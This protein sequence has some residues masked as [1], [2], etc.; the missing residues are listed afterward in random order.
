MPDGPLNVKDFA[1]SIKAQ[2]PDYAEVDDYELT[3]RIL[4]KYPE[5]KDALAPTVYDKTLLRAN[6]LGIPTKFVDNLVGGESSWKANVRDSVQGA[7]GLLQVM[8]DNPGGDTR[9]IGKKTYNL[10]N[11]NDN[12]E[13]GL[14]Y[15]KQG[16]DKY[17]GALD[18]TAAYYFSGSHA[19][20]PE[21]WDQIRDQTGT[22]VSQYVRKATRGLDSRAARIPSVVYPQN[23]TPTAQRQLLPRDANVPTDSTDTLSDAPVPENTQP[24]TEAGRAKVLASPDFG[25]EM[26]SGQTPAERAAMAEAQNRPNQIDD[27][28]AQA[29][30]FM[31]AQHQAVL[32]Q[33]AAALRQQAQA[34]QLQARAAQVAQASATSLSGFTGG[35][36]G[37]RGPEVQDNPQQPQEPIPAT[38]GVGNL[39]MAEG[40]ELNASGMGAGELRRRDDKAMQTARILAEEQA[41][42]GPGLE[43]IERRLQARG[44]GAPPVTPSPELMKK[45]EAARTSSVA[46]MDV[47]SAANA[48][49][50][51]PRAEMQ[52][53]MRA[54]DA[55]IET[56]AGKRKIESMAQ[57]PIVG[58]L[59]ASIAQQWP[60]FA[61]MV[62]Q[63]LGNVIQNPES[64]SP[65]Q[66]ALNYLNPAVGD[67]WKKMVAPVSD[68][69]K[70]RAEIN[71]AI[72]NY[73]P[74]PQ[75]A[76]GMPET[77]TRA[78]VNAGYDASRIGAIMAVTG[79]PLPVVLVGESAATNADKPFPTQLKENAKAL[80]IGLALHYVPTAIEKGLEKVPGIG[81]IA[82]AH[83]EAAARTVGA[84][85]F[86][87]LSGA[88]SAY[89][90]QDT[91]HVVAATAAG[92]VIGG[93][94]AGGGPMRLGK[95]VINRA[96]KSE[97]LPEPANDFLAS[98]NKLGKG[99]VF[100][101]DGRAASVY[102]DKDTGDAFG[103][104]LTPEQARAYD[105][106]IITGTA[107]PVRPSTDTLT[108]E[109]FD[110][111]MG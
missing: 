55:A 78:I 25:L 53:Q 38:G 51:L 47:F 67:N 89:Q 73:E 36:S 86:G 54:R 5:Y 105:P 22:T 58:P 2:H 72:G 60:R 14:Q 71:A 87:G 98:V 33:R 65:A 84:V 43:P 81:A 16:Y 23:P 49:P 82:A 45:L 9:T 1:A 17:N 26:G 111:L 100:S 106:S 24:M 32:K 11:L 109:A 4:D 76:S 18:R 57:D 66:A 41:R 8:P 96:I 68:Y 39:R 44:V 108:P 83:P 107:R 52:R 19:D 102:I 48:D 10:S 37:E 7:K 75:S 21:R 46:L 74:T 94:L 15:L 95:D 62:Q 27:V 110:A 79:L 61:G 88:E 101:S 69:L 99:V 70:H 77:I 42:Q 50:N 35:A 97:I 34:R 91:K 59:E 12:I 6:Q 90:G 80:A 3:N 31:S 20:T 30:A 63:E 92:A 85:G 40:R 103:N 64:L 93:T 28:N 29:M 104:T 13:A 56:E